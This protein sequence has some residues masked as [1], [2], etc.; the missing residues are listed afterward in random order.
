MAQDRSITQQQLD[1][2]KL[3]ILKGNFIINSNGLV[4]LTLDNEIPTREGDKPTAFSNI[5]GRAADQEFESVKNGFDISYSLA[6]QAKGNIKFLQY[7]HES[8]KAITFHV[9][10]LNKLEALDKTLVP[11]QKE[12][13]EDKAIE[14]KKK[15]AQVASSTPRSSI[16]IDRKVASDNARSDKLQT[17]IMKLLETELAKLRVKNVGGYLSYPFGDKEKIKNQLESYK[18]K[19]ALLKEA[20]QLCKQKTFNNDLDDMTEK[21]LEQTTLSAGANKE[22]KTWASGIDAK[23]NNMYQ[24][25]YKQGVKL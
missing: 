23:I 24:A 22:L 25:Y 16:D 15:L 9:G 6:G 2:L 14:E 10:N 1:N 18:H 17:D 4:T 11:F 19:S 20:I 13:E 12:Y 8:V 5:L 3:N 7:E 21:K